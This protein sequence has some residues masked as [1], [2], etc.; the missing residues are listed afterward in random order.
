MDTPKNEEEGTALPENLRELLKSRQDGYRIETGHVLGLRSDTQFSPAVFNGTTEIV[1]TLD[2]TLL[3]KVWELLPPRDS[4]AISNGFY[5]NSKIKVGY[6]LLGGGEVDREVSKPIRFLTEERFVEV[7]AKSSQPFEW[8]APG[9]VSA[10]LCREEFNRILKSAAE[11]YGFTF[12][13][14]MC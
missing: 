8:W 11:K 9:L 1:A 2:I 4:K 6:P 7:T 13:P 3:M 5:Y 12:N 14:K 10:A